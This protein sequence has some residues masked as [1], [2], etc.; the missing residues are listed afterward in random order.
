MFFKESQ[1]NKKILKYTGIIIGILFLGLLLLLSW[2]L[3]PGFQ[4][5]ETSPYQ[6]PP[7]SPTTWDKVFE[8][9][10]DITVEPLVTAMTKGNF[11][12]VLDQN[13]PNLKHIED[14]T[15]PLSILVY[16]LH[17]KEFGDILI[18]A[19]FDSSF[20]ENP[21]YGDSPLLMVLVYRLLDMEAYQEEDQNIAQ[22]LANRNI[23]PARVFFTHLHSDH[24]VG[25]TDLPNEIEVI[26]GKS[27]MIFSAKVF[28]GNPFKGKTNI[29]TLDFSGAK[30]VAPFEAVL[31][32]FGDGSLWAISTPGHSPD[33]ISFLV[34]AKSGPVLITGDAAHT[35][36]QFEY[37]IRPLGPSEEAVNQIMESMRSLK[38]LIK[39]Y[40][41]IEVF[42]G[43][44]LR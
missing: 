8:N 38:D 28:M 15:K 1:M 37:E 19:G 23:T 18:D 20:A 16:L 12:Q 41:Q 6:I 2:L 11:C 22:Q 10:V 27:E 34:N 35:Y 26:F 30:P 4:S 44:E 9:P 42:V 14:C 31:D 36:T 40:P 7:Q 3:W 25:A 13:D 5:I 39:Q 21:P 17:H 33:H 32:V 43:H 29:K 24:V